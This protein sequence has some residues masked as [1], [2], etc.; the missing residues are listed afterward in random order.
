MQEYLQIGEIVNTHG[1][2][3]ELKVVPLTDDPKRFEDLEWVYVDKISSM[4]KMHIS[5]VKYFKGFVFLNL[6]EINDMGAAEAL[7]GYF[8]KVDRENA[9]KLPEYTFFISD[10]IDCEVFDVAGKCLG[11]LKSIIKTGSNDVY[12]VKSEDNKEILIPA[13]KSVVKDICIKNRRITVLLPEGLV[14]DE[15]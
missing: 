3:G 4:E 8:L 14:N 2:K 7:K 15:I 12:V 1:I 11:R 10:L 6:K 9:V 13:L 5:E